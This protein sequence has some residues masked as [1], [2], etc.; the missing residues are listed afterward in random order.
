MFVGKYNGIKKKFKRN[1][2]VKD[3]ISISDCYEP[4]FPSVPYFAEMPLNKTTKTLLSFP[5]GTKIRFDADMYEHGILKNV[6][7]IEVV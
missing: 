2:R 1:V 4:E 3:V 5:V 6:V 7:N